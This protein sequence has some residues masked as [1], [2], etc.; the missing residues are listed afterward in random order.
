MLE[1]MAA[2]RTLMGYEDARIVPK[3]S[4]WKERSGAIAKPENRKPY[5]NSN[6]LL[7]SDSAVVLSSNTN[8]ERYVTVIS[9]TYAGE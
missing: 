2:P 3:N 9:G 5:G 6:G 7:Q 1:D 8:Q 4:V